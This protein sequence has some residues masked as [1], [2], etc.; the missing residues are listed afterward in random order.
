MGDLRK[1]DRQS[2]TVK[3]DRLRA[4][5]SGREGDQGLET[6]R[7]QRQPGSQSETGDTFDEEDRAQRGQGRNEPEGGEKGRGRE[8]SGGGSSGGREDRGGTN[9]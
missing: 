5:D 6:G 8:E 7:S 4:P 9:R 1:P 2:D 3:D